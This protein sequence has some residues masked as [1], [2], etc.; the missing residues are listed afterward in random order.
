YYMKEEWEHIN[1]QFPKGA[2]HLRFT[3]SHDETRAVVRYG[4][5]GALAAQVLMLTLDGVPLFYNG[6]E[7]GD[8]TESADPALFEKMPVFWHPGGR[9]PLHDIYRDLI[10]LRK[11][12]AAFY[13]GEVVWLENTAP[14]EVVSILRRDAKDEFLVLIN[15]SSRRVSGSIEL[16]NSEG[17][18]PVNISSEAKPVGVVLPDFSL[19]GYGWYIYHRAVPK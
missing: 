17:F 19:S 6:M 3:D 10:K 1:Q 14:G 8:A 13:N 11:Q 12:N 15:F 16:S 18:E 5:D 2:L 9:P 4:V 7:V